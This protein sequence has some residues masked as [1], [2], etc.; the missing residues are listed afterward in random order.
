MRTT[1]TRITLLVALAAALAAPLA[2]DAAHAKRAA[3]A[4]SAKSSRLD[5]AAINDVAATPLLSQGTRGGAVV[6]AQILLDRKW[7]SPGEIDGGFGEN[8]RKAVAS[9]QGAN[10]LKPSG[11]IDADTWQA[12]RGSDDHVLTAYTLTDKDVA[13]PFVKIPRD[14]MDR[15][16]LD[17]LGYENVVE[18]LAEKF[19]SNPALLRGLNP[20]K[21]FE[22]GDELL[23]PDILSAKPPAKA[24]SITLAKKERVLQALDRDGRVLAQFPI[25]VAGKRDELPSGRFKIVSEVKDPVFHFDPAKLNDTNPRHSKATIPPGP[26]SPV[27]VVWMGLDKPHY[28]IHGTPQ[29]E[30]VGR[31]ETNGCIH[32]TNWDAMKLAA[33]ASPGVAVNVEG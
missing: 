33:I 13:G 15:A 9:F 24:A 10:G 2:A 23:V 19:H 7:F 5:T 6:R 31:I 3:P 14:M 32:L 28:G 22:A 21:T 4:H 1:R 18:A 17:R 26:N 27:G 8:M 11:K 16:Q 30:L 20:G 12:L 25:S 29:P